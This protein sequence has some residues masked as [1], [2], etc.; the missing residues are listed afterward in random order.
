MKKKI[1][2]KTMLIMLALVPLILAVVI[3]AFASSRVVV[4]NLKQNTREELMLAAK[5][6]REY[7]EYD[8]T[9]EYDLVDGFIK[10]DT[11]YIDSINRTGVDLTLFK[12]NM[13]FMTTIKDSGGKRIEGTPASAAVWEAV[14]GGSDYY[15]DNVKI[16]GIDYHVYYMPIVS[17]GKV[18]G[19]AFSGKP[20][21]QIQE[22]VKSIYMLIIEISAGLILFFM[23]I[24]WPA[25][26]RIA[27]PLKEVA[28]RIEHLLD[29]SKST[30]IKTTSNIYE[31]SQ[32]ILAANEIS[33]VLAEAAGKIHDTAFSLADDVKSTAV[34]ANNSSDSATGIASSMRDLAK[35]TA[36]MAD[37]V[38]HISGNISDMG[39]IIAQAVNNV[40]NL[41]TNSQAMNKA[42]SEALECIENVEKSADKSTEAAKIIT[43]RIKS[44]NESINKIEEMVQIIAAIASQTNLLSLNASIEAARAGE[45]GRGF[46]V[47]AAEIKKLAAQSRES[48]E[49]IESIVEEIGALSGECVN[50]AEDIRALLDEERSVLSTAQGKF[51]ELDSKI[52]ASVRETESVAEI[53]ARLDGIKD[54]ILSA[55]ENL[56][57]ISEE[58]SATNEEVAASAGTIADS[59]KKVSDHTQSMNGLAEDLKEAVE[60]FH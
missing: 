29:V 48:A 27:D 19:M 49:Q 45:A 16:N 20:A 12:G 2:L 52:N 9:N 23:L 43:D 32:L 47:V 11:S 22:A 37:S 25:S 40:D 7:Y 14:R 21:T 42:N 33:S 39:S 1:S 41:H 50:A 60:Y 38:H 30:K 18:I 13:R 35:T 46:G 17:K 34:L 15:S 4:N 59:V 31:T 8:F 44:T 5:G 53:T 55:V 24:A 56:A 36:S 10:Y 57:A 28:D 51:R 6:L 26:K 58:T 54:T 3:I